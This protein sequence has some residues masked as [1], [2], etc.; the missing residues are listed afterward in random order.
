[1]AECSWQGRAIAP[2][3]AV[4]EALVATTALSFFGGVDPE[5][6]IVTEKGHVLAGQTIAGRIL[7]F[8][9]G[10]GSTVGSYILYRLKRAG[11]APLA[12]INAECEPIIAVGCILAEIPCADHIPIEQ[13]RNGDYLTVKIGD[14]GAA[15]CRHAS[16]T[17]GEGHCM[18]QD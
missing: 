11:R 13:I 4:G 3:Y 5:S 8:P 2:G 7:V 1:M 18:T 12:I 14:E 9:R 10:K 15:I 6:G 16:G 17:G